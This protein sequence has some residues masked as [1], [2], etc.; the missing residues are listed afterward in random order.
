MRYVPCKLNSSIGVADL[1]LGR[2]A[3]FSNTLTSRASLESRFNRWCAG[4][5]TAF[6]WLAWTNLTYEWVLFTEAQ[7]VSA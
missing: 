4:D 2:V 3:P 6:N 1:E 7:E 5:S